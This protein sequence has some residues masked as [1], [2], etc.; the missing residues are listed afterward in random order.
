MYKEK[1]DMQT[2]GTKTV[3]K[4][5]MGRQLAASP[6][7]YFSKTAEQTREGFTCAHAV[8]RLKTGTFCPI[9]FS[10]SLSRTSLMTWGVAELA[11][12]GF[13]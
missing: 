9:L 8:L 11:E 3:Y 2:G 1:F 5:V 6:R 12:T 7:H 10:L 13:I 4:S